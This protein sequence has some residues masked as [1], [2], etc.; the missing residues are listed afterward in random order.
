MHRSFLRRG[1]A[2]V[3]VGLFGLS[4]AGCGGGSGGGSKLDG[5]YRGVT[6]GPITLNIKD[7]KATVAVAN[8]SK[9]LDYKVEGNKLTI[10]DPQAGNIVFTIND[11]GTLNGE[12]GIMTKKSS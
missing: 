1:A 9:T 3:I 11:D 12:L 5:F 2:L 10:L 4:L 6:G 8:E 7:G